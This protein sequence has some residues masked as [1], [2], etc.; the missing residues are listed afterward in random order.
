[1]P[2]MPQTM[3]TRWRWG[4]FRADATRYASSIS[5]DVVLAGRD[6]FEEPCRS[7]L[8]AL[9][10]DPVDAEPDNADGYGDGRLPS[11]GPDWWGRSRN[12][13]TGID[14]DTLLL[15]SASE[16]PRRHC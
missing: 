6:L 5:W 7:P 11:S 14:Q 16:P 15:V 9:L 13:C 3:P 1:M 12:F 8:R 4:Q 10:A 2:T